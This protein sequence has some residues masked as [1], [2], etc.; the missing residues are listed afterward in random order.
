MD[1][2]FFLLNLALVLLDALLILSSKASIWDFKLTFSFSKYMNFLASLESL[3]QL[4]LSCLLVRG[5]SN[6]DCLDCQFVVPFAV[7]KWHPLQAPRR[8]TSVGLVV[9]VSGPGLHPC[10]APDV[11]YSGE[12]LIKS[13]FLNRE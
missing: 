9:K 1:L 2:I 6:S 5:A 4:R 10:F 8:E 3:F 11:H 13:A 12:K 7:P